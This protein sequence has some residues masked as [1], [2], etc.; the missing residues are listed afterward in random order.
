MELCRSRASRLAVLGGAGVWPADILCESAA[1]SR[2]KGRRGLDV[3][4]GGWKSRAAGGGDT[5]ST[6][7]DSSSDDMLLMDSSHVSGSSSLS[8]VKSIFCAMELILVV[9]LLSTADSRD[10]CREWLDL[11]PFT[12]TSQQRVDISGPKFRQTHNA[13][14]WNYNNT[15]KIPKHDIQNCKAKIIL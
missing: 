2:E 7:D 1:G 14:C 15:T 9:A 5:P 3:I 6:A 4:D 8:I 11:V 13:K 10:R 12:I